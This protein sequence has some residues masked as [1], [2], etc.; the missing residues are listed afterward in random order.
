MPQSLVR[1][2]GHLVFSTKKRVPFIDPKIRPHLY[3]YMAGILERDG[4]REILIGGTDDHIHA[5]MVLSK[6]VAQIKLVENL[7]KRSSVW[8]KEQD[9]RYRDFYW[10]SGY[11]LFSVSPSNVTRVRAYIENQETHHKSMSFQDELRILLRKHGI[12]FD[13]RYLWD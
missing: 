4:C 2:I 9:P 8:M 11:A 6:S 12:E 5:V 10:Q 7:K 13:E 3:G 1:V